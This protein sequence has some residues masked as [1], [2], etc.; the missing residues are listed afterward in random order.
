MT[1]G[2]MN[3]SECAETSIE[4][5]TKSGDGRRHRVKQDQMVNA[6]KNCE[7]KGRKVSM[8]TTPRSNSL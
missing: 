6:N 4:N 1:S 3:L 7:R 5:Y 2:R 8:E